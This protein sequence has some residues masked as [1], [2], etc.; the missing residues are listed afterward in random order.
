MLQAVQG[1]LV[2]LVTAGVLF[3]GFCFYQLCI[4][5]FFGGEIWDMIVY[6]AACLIML[7]LFLY[8]FCKGM[9]WIRQKQYRR[10][11]SEKKF[12][13]TKRRV[14]IDYLQVLC[15]TGLFYEGVAYVNASV[16]WKQDISRNMVFMLFGLF[17]LLTLK[18]REAVN[19]FSG[20]WIL[21]LIPAGIYYCRLSGEDAHAVEA[22]RLLV[23][24]V[25]LWGIVLGASQRNLRRLDGH[26]HYQEGRAPGQDYPTAQFPYNRR[27]DAGR[28]VWHGRLRYSGRKSGSAA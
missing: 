10:E 23:L 5:R 17:V 19:I 12:I 1:C 27:N 2:A 8:A 9:A 6:A 3:V 26:G 14:W 15:L 28:P 25:G 13:K 22:A 4:V 20:L 16:Q 7:C 11:L 21:V 18:F 24:A